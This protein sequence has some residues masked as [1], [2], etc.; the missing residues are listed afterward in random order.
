MSEKLALLRA[1]LAAQTANPAGN[2]PKVDESAALTAP[3]NNEI[4]SEV[5]PARPAA[6]ARKLESKLGFE[7]L[8]K[9]NRL[10]QNLLEQHPLLPNLLREI[11]KA[12]AVQPENVILMNEE[13]LAIL[14]SGLDKQTGEELASLRV[15]QSKKPGGKAKAGKINVASL[16]FD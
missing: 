10:E 13:E 16:G 11:Y 8:E 2:N 12:L 15:S 6:P 14:V 3:R 1:K 7:F 5:V 4:A 9:L